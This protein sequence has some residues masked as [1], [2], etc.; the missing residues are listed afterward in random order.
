MENVPE[1]VGKNNI[2]DFKKWEEKLR[3]FGYKNYVEILNAKDYGIPQNRRR[4]FMVSLLGDYAYEFPRKHY[5]QRK[6]KDFLEDNVDEKY[7]LSPKDIER[8]SQWNAREKP[9][10]NIIDPNDKEKV[11]SALTARGAGEDHSGMK[12]IGESKYSDKSLERI[13]KNVCEDDNAPTIT[14]N[15]MQSVNHQNCV[16]IK[17][18][19][20]QGYKEAKEGD[21][22]NLASR[23][24]HQRGNVQRESIQ[25]LKAQMEVGV[26]V[27]K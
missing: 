12:L 17:E 25:T 10:E 20:L 9:L 5:L 23:M 11:M 13:A 6:L 22:I 4:C 1:V 15:A 19:N 18:N 2:D 27:K 3:S 24:A 16:L 8:I 7:Y 21:G 14:A 26:V